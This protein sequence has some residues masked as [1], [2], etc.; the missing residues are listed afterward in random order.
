MWLVAFLML[1]QAPAGEVKK[2]V[3]AGAAGDELIF[4][5]PRTGVTLKLKNNTVSSSTINVSKVD[6]NNMRGN[7]K[8]NTVDLHWNNDRVWGMIG[9]G[10]Q[11][12]LKVRNTEE[13]IKVDG[14]FQGVTS[15]FRIGYGILDGR[16]GS[17]RYNLVA[18]TDEYEGTRV[19]DN[20]NTF[21][22][23][24]TLKMPKKLTSR[25]P[26][27]FIAWFAVA[28]LGQRD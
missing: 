28:M 21:T 14:T 24:V 8:G 1:Q 10:T 18:Q 7:Y 25:Q 9:S 19:C 26:T 17:C 13:G 3:V 23:N 22:E 6:G 5:A 12:N 27:E 2:D 11:M 20:R 16:I 4:S 15:H